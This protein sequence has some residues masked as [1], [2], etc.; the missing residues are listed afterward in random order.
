MKAGSMINLPLNDNNNKKIYPEIRKW[1]PSLRMVMIHLWIWN[2]Q[3]GRKLR[4]I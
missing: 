3:L 4:A 1:G 2:T